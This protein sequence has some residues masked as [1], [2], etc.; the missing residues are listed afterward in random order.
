[1]TAT[2]VLFDIDDTLVDLATAM[3]DALGGSLTEVLPPGA[4][5]LLGLGSGIPSMDDD[6]EARRRWLAFSEHF[7]PDVSGTY[8]DY[9]AG[10]LSF[11]EM[12]ILRLH[13]AAALLGVTV[14]DD[15]AHRWVER[16]AELAQ[17]GVRPFPDVVQVLDLL[18]AHGIPYGAVSN[19]VEDFQRAKLG[20]AGLS[21]I[22]VVVGTDTMGVTKPDPAIFREGVRQLGVAVADCW[23][24]GDNPVVDHDGAVAAGLRGVYLDR[25]VMGSG[26]SGNSPVPVPARNPG[27]RLTI[28]GLEE[29][30][31]LLGLAASVESV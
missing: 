29:L 27:E 12:R 7:V 24:V 22:S 25:G 26:S 23:Y 28:H 21:R 30:P 18:D 4:S 11:E 10:R 1:M 5:A 15:V 13:R 3:T 9:L 14:P 20:H 6:G 19:N 17:T 31:L 8:D 2:G 16:F